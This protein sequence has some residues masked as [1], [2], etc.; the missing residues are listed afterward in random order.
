MNLLNE[1]SSLYITV[2]NEY[3]AK[4]IRSDGHYILPQIPLVTFI[5]HFLRC[6]SSPYIEH[7]LSTAINY[8]H[9][10]IIKIIQ[11]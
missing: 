10:C 11:E 4:C 2:K 9:Q 7:S 3:V 6:I 5:I 8:Y 1:T